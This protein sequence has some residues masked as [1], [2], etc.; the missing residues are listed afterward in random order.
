MV[1]TKRGL[2]RIPIGDFVAKNLSPE[3]AVEMFK[4]KVRYIYQGLPTRPARYLL[5]AMRRP[6]VPEMISAHREMKHKDPLPRAMFQ[7]GLMLEIQPKFG[8]RA[9]SYFISENGLEV[10]RYWAETNREFHAYANAYMPFDI[11]VRIRLMRVDVVLG[12]TP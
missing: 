10:I 9:T 2:K 7:A 12:V 11:D 5:T 3:N 6:V 8:R 1:N 4:T